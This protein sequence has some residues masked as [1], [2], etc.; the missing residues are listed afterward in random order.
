[1]TRRPVRVDARA[2]YFHAL[3]AHRHFVGKRVHVGNCVHVGHRTGGTGM[4]E[5][6]G[7]DHSIRAKNC[8]RAL[9]QK[10]L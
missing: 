5:S 2:G 10:V 8:S 4:L 6:R 7:K 3:R 1:M 9:F